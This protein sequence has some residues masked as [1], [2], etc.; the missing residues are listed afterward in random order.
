M[1]TP[2]TFSTDILHFPLRVLVFQTAGSP[3]I[4][5]RRTGACGVPVVGT[6]V[7]SMVTRPRRLTGMSRTTPIGLSQR[8]SGARR[9]A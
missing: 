8:V 7:S 1:T 9:R 2:R 6:A 5:S 3:G 4:A